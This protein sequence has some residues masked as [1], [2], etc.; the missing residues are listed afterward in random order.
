MALKIQN[1]WHKLTRRRKFYRFL[2][3]IREAKRK[4]LKLIVK[5]R[6][7]KMIRLVINVN[8]AKKR[9]IMMALYGN[10]YK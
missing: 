3:L 5:K 2:A 9:F 4:F 1:N 10:K 6:L 7:I 8:K